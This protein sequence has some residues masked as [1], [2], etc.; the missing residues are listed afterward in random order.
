M[1]GSA[2]WAYLQ[3]G[4]MP[5]IV[6]LGGIAFPIIIS[7]F[8]IGAVVWMAVYLV[9]RSRPSYFRYIKNTLFVIAAVVI[10]G[11]LYGV[12][13]KQG[14]G[15]A[16]ETEASSGEKRSSDANNVDRGEEVWVNIP[17]KWIEKPN[18]ESE[19]DGDVNKSNKDGDEFIVIRKVE[20]GDTVETWNETALW[21]TSVQQELVKWVSKGEPMTVMEDGGNHYKVKHEEYVGYVRKNNLEPGD[22]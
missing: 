20:K 17:D 4:P 16:P 3:Q 13:E 9:K 7:S 15:V 10:G 12:V 11:S 18:K 6:F 2:G 8:G 1:P 5:L 22:R 21:E 19:N 14:S